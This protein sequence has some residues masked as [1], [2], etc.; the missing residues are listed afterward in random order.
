M[1]ING[2]FADHISASDRSFQYGDGCFTTMLTRHGRIQQWQYHQERMQ[3]CL[4]MLGIVLADWADVESWLA[5]AILP[6]TQAGL[7]LHVSRGHGGR[8]Y[9]AAQVSQPTVTIRAFA[10]PHHYTTWQS[11]GIALGVCQH[12]LGLSP[13]LAGHK[14]NNR[15]EQVLMKAEMDSAGHPDGLC[16]DING[17]V[18][19]TT[20]ANIFW[21]KDGT[22]YTPDL[23]NSGV[24]GVARRRV[25]E[26][27]KYDELDLAIGQYSLAAIWDADEVFITNA[28]LGVAPVRQIQQ[29]VYSIGS[30]TRRFQKRFHLC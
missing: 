8:G 4:D 7:K 5:Q 1:L 17:H 20:M 18:I 19:E 22:L 10:F 25:I 21:V 16:C 6:D 9:S 2:V 3:A 23:A 27:T 28:M 30:H 24:A 13:L 11:D 15:L 26:L 14:H 12:P 29:Q